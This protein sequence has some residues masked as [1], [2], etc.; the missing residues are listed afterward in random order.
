MFSRQYSHLRKSYFHHIQKYIHV[1]QV[2]HLIIFAESKDHKMLTWR[3][4]NVKHVYDVKGSLSLPKCLMVSYVDSCK[5]SII[6]VFSIVIIKIISY[7]HIIITIMIYFIII[8]III[9]FITIIIIISLL[10]LLILLSSPI[11]ITIIIF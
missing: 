7:C 6:R 8:I 1:F 2:G 9:T 11:T 4:E 10:L 3:N 5:C